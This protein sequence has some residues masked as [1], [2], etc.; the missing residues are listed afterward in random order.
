[1][2]FLPPCLAAVFPPAIECSGEEFHCVVDGT[3]IPERWR[4]D[5][6]KDCDDGTDESGCEGT[7]RMCD[8]KAK[9]TCKDTGNPSPS[10]AL[11]FRF[12][13]TTE[14]LFFHTSL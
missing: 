5:A 10:A 6:D 8:P 4:C 3:C 12:I 11:G 2:A 7:K 13:N 9:F 1:V 14:T